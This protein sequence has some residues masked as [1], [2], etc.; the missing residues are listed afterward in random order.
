[1]SQDVKNPNPVVPE[2]GPFEMDE[3]RGTASDSG[4]SSN[5]SA[6]AGEEKKYGKGPEPTIETGDRRS[7]M[8]RP[9]AQDQKI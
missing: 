4:E 6:S 2:P 9:D 1:M 8:E 5:R 3:E 7:M